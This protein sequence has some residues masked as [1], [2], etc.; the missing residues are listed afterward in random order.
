MTP[1][2]S[3]QSSVPNDT[4]DGETELTGLTSK[5]VIIGSSY[6]NEEESY[7]LR[8]MTPANTTVTEVADTRTGT[9]LDGTLNIGNPAGATDTNVI[10]T[11]FYFDSV[12]MTNTDL[13]NL[14]GAIKQF[15][16]DLGRL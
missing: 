8:F 11:F 13:Q 6:L 16:I 5:G 7:A 1:E 15:N 14:Y 4:A 2:T 10:S 9:T 3:P 12:L